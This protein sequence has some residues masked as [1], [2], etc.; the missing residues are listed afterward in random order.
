MEKK[1]K[2]NASAPTSNGTVP[3]NS[4]PCF[5][6]NNGLKSQGVNKKQRNPHRKTVQPHF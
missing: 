5:P 2:Q 4:V 3:Q 1:K 6:E